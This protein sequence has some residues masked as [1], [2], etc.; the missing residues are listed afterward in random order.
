MWQTGGA[1]V[2]E[3]VWRVLVF[4][5]TLHQKPKSKKIWETCHQQQSPTS[6]WPATTGK[7]QEGRTADWPL[8]PITTR[9]TPSS[10]RKWARTIPPLSNSE[11]RWRRKQTSSIWEA[12]T[13][14]PDNPNK[15]SPYCWNTR[16]GELLFITLHWKLTK[17]EWFEEKAKKVCYSWEKWLSLSHRSVTYCK[18]FH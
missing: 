12:K 15:N 11:R 3:K 6:S 2:T 18:T 10:S 14:E 8:L 5:V 13:W 16:Y 17:L 7:G 9:P 1:F 4:A